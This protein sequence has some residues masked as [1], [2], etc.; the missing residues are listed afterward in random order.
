LEAFFGRLPPE[1]G[2]AFVVVTHLDPSRES[3]LAETLRRSQTRV[4]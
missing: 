1:S 3:L 4:D 2:I